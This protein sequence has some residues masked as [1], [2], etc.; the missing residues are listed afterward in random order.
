LYFGW[1]L[2][3]QS[4]DLRILDY[5]FSIFN[6]EEEPINL[7]AFVFCIYFKGFEKRNYAAA[8][9]VYTSAAG[10]HSDASAATYFQ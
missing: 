9:W 7:N 8:T 3:C 2:H 1:P 6:L 4:F 5:P 10:K